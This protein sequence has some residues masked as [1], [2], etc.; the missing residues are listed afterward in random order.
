MLQTI[1]LQCSAVPVMRLI[2]RCLTLLGLGAL[3]GAACGD[4]SAGDLFTDGPAIELGGRGGRGSSRSGAGGGAG[5][6]SLAGSDS[7]GA[8]GAAPDAG[9]VDCALG[10]DDQN[11]CTLDTCVDGSCE[12]SPAPAGTPCGS[13][14]DGECTEPDTC[15]DQGVCLVNDE[16]GTEC[17]G[18]TCQGGLCVTAQNPD[19]PAQVVTALPFE[20]SWRTVG[21]VNL[22]NGDC[23]IENTPDFAVVFTA[24][25]TGNYV[26][27]AAGVEGDGDP[28]TDMNP[29]A[30]NLADSLLVIA[31]GECAGL[32]AQQLG[33]DDDT[34]GNFDSRIM[35]RLNAGETVTV[36]AS[37][38]G[39]PLPG[40]GSGTLSIQLQGN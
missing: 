2:C 30:V 35:I 39:E 7:G 21:G 9:V 10:C 12:S 18:G 4:G 3:F 29:N 31:A 5:I 13:D 23:D 32:G 1:V 38:V 34:G 6:P 17:D 14:V 26:F 25:E 27:E 37:E 19:C 16:D 36:Y 24:P 20:A 11:D 33:C 28:E 22:Y 8:G 15:D 40:G